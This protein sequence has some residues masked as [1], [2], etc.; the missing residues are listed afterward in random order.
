LIPAALAAA[1]AVAGTRWALRSPG[2]DRSGLA[3][4][5]VSGEVRRSVAT[6]A[7]RLSAA[8]RLL[9]AADALTTMVLIWGMVWTTL[10]PSAT[11]L[12]RR[13]AR[14]AALRARTR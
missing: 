6:P 14:S 8:S 1:A 9:V 7:A 2:A 10:A 5:T 11:A 12:A 4:S 3:R 13:A